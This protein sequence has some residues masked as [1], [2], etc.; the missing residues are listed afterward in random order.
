MESAQYAKISHSH[1][2][3]GW[4]E[5][6]EYLMYRLNEM[7]SLVNFQSNYEGR[8]DIKEH[9]SLIGWLDTVRSHVQGHSP[10]E[11]S[12]AIGMSAPLIGLYDMKMDGAYHSLMFHIIGNSSMGKSSAAALAVSPF[13]RPTNKGLVKNFNG[14]ANALEQHVANNYGVPIVLDET[15]MHTLTTNQLSTFVYQIADNQGKNRLNKEAEMKDVLMW[16][17]TII[18]TGESSILRETKANVGLRV[19]LFELNNIA[20]TQSAEHAEALNA[21][22]QKNYGHA[23]KIFVES[24]MRLGLAKIDKM[25]HECKK[26]LVD[27]LPASNYRERIAG[28][29]AFVLLASKLANDSLQL[30]LSTS[31]ILRLL[32][33]QEQASLIKRELAESF[34]QNLKAKIIEYVGHFKINNE[35]P[36][37]NK[38]V[39]GKITIKGSQTSIF[40]LE[41]AY[42]KF[43]EELRITNV[44]VLLNDL[45]EKGFLI[46]DQNKNKKRTRIDGN[47]VYTICLRYDYNFLN[48]YISD[49]KLVESLDS[50]KVNS[51]YPRKPKKRPF[52]ESKRDGGSLEVLLNG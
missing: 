19:R 15:S 13:G 5:L 9:G 12:L 31:E 42:R 1:S 26:E 30:S 14:T 8:M 18:L 11:L 52:V 45:K 36:T 29:F 48:E 51:V 4:V 38:S 34:H 50:E 32:V 21:G 47:D 24:I 22:I 23:G 44:D 28:K 49:Y 7:V 3:I 41:S 33:E 43:A 40:L 6:E 2:N 25:L 27:A 10:L 39:F 46:H 16:A 35:K 17:T 37:T 20:W